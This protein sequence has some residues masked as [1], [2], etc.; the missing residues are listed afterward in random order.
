MK[1]KLLLSP[2]LFIVFIGTAS[3]QTSKGEF[4]L[5]GSMSYNYD[6]YGSTSTYSYLSGYTNYYVTKVAA[7]NISPEIGYF[8]SN[9]WSIG[10]APTYA[11]NS[12]TETSYFYS[13][14][15]TADNTISS[16]T[17]HTNS[18]GLGID[19]RYYCMITDKFGF[20]PQAGISTLNNS[21]YFSDGT[22]A[23]GATP[24]FVFF[25]TPK[26]AVN[27]GFGSVGYSLDYQTKDHAVNAS[28]NNSITF[29]L[30]YLW[31]GK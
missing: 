28:L 25:A 20:F 1:L 17:Y 10:I 12:G 31:D 4:Y 8:I 13:Y 16:D 2:I 24:N 30:N 19:V 22:L 14:T 29:G 21:T 11:R 15:S 6:S 5:G 26:L 7:F 3:A 27:L 9:K 23:I 18:I